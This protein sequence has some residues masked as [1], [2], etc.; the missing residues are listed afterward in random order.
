VSQ[1]RE[2]GCSR[3]RPLFPRRHELPVRPR[4]TDFRYD[5]LGTTQ[6][7]GAAKERS[8]EIGTVEYSFE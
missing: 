4:G 7:L 5:E 2:G 6:E 8:G 1:V 3:R